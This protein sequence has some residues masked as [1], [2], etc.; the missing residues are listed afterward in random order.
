MNSL[1]IMAQLK[2][3]AAQY[4]CAST[5]LFRPASCMLNVRGRSPNDIC[6]LNNAY[7]IANEHTTNKCDHVER[8]TCAKADGILQ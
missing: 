2:K 7:T 1:M 6:V 5:S 4:C 8:A 3:K